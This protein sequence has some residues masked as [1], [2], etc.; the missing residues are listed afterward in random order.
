MLLD[1][2]AIANMKNVWDETPLH[3]VSRGE[4]ESGERGVGVAIARLLLKRSVDVDARKDDK[5]TPL[6]LA[7]LTGKP[8]VLGVLLEHG[9]NANSEDDRGETPTHLVSQGRYDAHEYGANILLT[10]LERGAD[11]NYPNTDR[12]TP[13]HTASYFGTL[14]VARMLL[15]HGANTSSEND[16]AQTPLHLVSQGQFWFQHDGP[17]VAKL[18]LEHGADMNA[19]D[20]DHVTPLHLACYHGRFDIVRVLLDYDAKA[21]TEE[22]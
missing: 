10:L 12:D 8:D 3:R 4:Y 13:L 17:G 22:D 21:G 5:S 16:R 2:G 15:N 6:H 18:L 9:A 11:V 7:A 20:K 1:H 14:E 19:R